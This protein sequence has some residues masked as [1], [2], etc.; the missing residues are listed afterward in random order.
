MHIFTFCTSARKPRTTSDLYHRPL[1]LNG[2]I[3]G[4]VGSVRISLPQVRLK[5][6]VQRSQDVPDFHFDRCAA[7]NRR[8]P[9]LFRCLRFSHG[10]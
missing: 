6:E 1:N 5:W 4:S 7:K 10:S 3:V 9:Y 8:T 2:T